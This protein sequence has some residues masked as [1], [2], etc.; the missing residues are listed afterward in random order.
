MSR[1]F[2]YLNGFDTFAFEIH[3]HVRLRFKLAV[4][5]GEAWTRDGGIP[6]RCPLSMVFVVAL[7]LPWC[8]CLEAIGDI[9]PQLYA[10]FEAC[11]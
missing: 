2:E 10:E 6:Q 4:G 11:R 1:F 7:Y 9:K 3:A 8:K 5:I